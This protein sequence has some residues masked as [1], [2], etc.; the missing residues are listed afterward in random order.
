MWHVLRTALQQGRAAGSAATRQRGRTA[1]AYTAA[2]SSHPQ[3]A[4]ALLML[5]CIGVLPR[6]CLTNC[7]LHNCITTYSLHNCLTNYSL[8]SCLTNYSLHNFLTNHSL[9]AGVWRTGN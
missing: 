9:H 5:T 3:V 7:F 4:S 1:V 6:N 2:V 8:H